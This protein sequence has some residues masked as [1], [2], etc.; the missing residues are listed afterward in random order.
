MGGYNN[1][2]AC[3]SGEEMPTGYTIDTCVLCIHVF[4][5]GWLHDGEHLH[6]CGHTIKLQQ[7]HAHHTRFK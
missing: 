5:Q 7:G 6:V 2:N 3:Y 1:Y 4:M